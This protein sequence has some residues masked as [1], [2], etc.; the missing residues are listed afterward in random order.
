[1][2][3]S[4]LAPCIK[5]LT[6]GT[7]DALEW[8][9]VIVPFVTCL[10]V[11][12]ADF[13]I[14]LEAR[15]RRSNWRRILEEREPGLKDLIPFDNVNAA[16][17]VEIQRLLG[18]ILAA[19]WIVCKAPEKNAFITTDLAYAFS[20]DPDGQLGISIPLDGQHVLQ[21]IPR[22]HGNVAIATENKC[23]PMLEHRTL[24]RDNYSQLNEALSH[25]S[26][27]F[28]FGSSLS[29]VQRYLRNARKD[30]LLLEPTDVGF[31]SGALARIHE[32]TWHR[33]VSAVSKH[34]A[35]AEIEKFEF[36]WQAIAAAWKPPAVLFPTNLP[37]FPPGLRRNGQ[38][39]SVT[40]YD[41]AGIST[42]GGVSP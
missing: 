23:Y 27:R 3:E 39:I 22:R 1:M 25:T 42:G 16:R 15:M 29:C 31:I 38:I 36:D 37:E 9:G 4:R 35:S 30:P 5:R 33:F 6:L 41:V 13:D 12:G 19:K 18:P 11:R 40:F 2:Y 32:F 34:P 17:S 14:R 26:R 10:L 7:I 8:A 24:R 21:L 20:K 28:I